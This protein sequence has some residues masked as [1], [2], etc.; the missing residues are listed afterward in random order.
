LCVLRENLVHIFQPKHNPGRYGF[1]RTPTNARDS[2]R[3][4]IVRSKRY[5]A[6][7]EEF[8][9]LAEDAVH[10]F[11]AA[12]TKSSV[13]RAGTKRDSNFTP[14]SIDFDTPR[15]LSAFLR[16]T[17]AVARRWQY[18]VHKKKDVEKYV[19]VLTAAFL[20]GAVSA[21]NPACKQCIL[22]HSFVPDG[23]DGIVCAHMPSTSWFE[24][25]WESEFELVKSP[26]GALC[27]HWTG[28][29]SKEQEVRSL[30]R[31]EWQWGDR[32]S[33]KFRRRGGVVGAISIVVP[34]VILRGGAAHRLEQRV[35]PTLRRPN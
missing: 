15:A 2:L 12:F 34:R 17:T 3:Y 21:D 16:C 20:E 7:Y 27:T 19:Y 22:L 4:D 24:G 6:L 1:W 8:L 23:D 5:A 14:F 28:C 10:N 29:G 33:T 30:Y 26:P 9:L 31:I 25:D 18:H 35:L 32:T 11:G 13:R